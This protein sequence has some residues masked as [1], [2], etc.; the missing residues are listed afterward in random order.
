[1]IGGAG[2]GVG[3]TEKP[4]DHNGDTAQIL[5]HARL[6]THAEDSEF[7]RGGLS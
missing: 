6:R 5:R 3:G 4:R 2:E 7:R 1:M